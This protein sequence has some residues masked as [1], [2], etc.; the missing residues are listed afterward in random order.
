MEALAERCVQVTGAGQGEC[1]GAEGG[2][3]YFEQRH[4]GFVLLTHQL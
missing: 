3:V 1:K 2:A 4:L